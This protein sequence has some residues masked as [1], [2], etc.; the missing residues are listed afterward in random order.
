MHACRCTKSYFYPLLVAKCWG[1]TSSE[2]TQEWY[3]PSSRCLAVTDDSSSSFSFEDFSNPETIWPS[4]LAWSRSF[5]GFLLRK[6][7]LLGIFDGLPGLCFLQLRV[8]DVP[9]LLVK[10]NLVSLL[11]LGETLFNLA[12]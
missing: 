6:E 10:R 3:F 9:G 12:F 11:R 8:S 4:S 5:G 7:F 1:I 2:D